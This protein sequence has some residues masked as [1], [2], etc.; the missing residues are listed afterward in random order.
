MPGTPAERRRKAMHQPPLPDADA[1][2]LHQPAGFDVVTIFEALHD[3]GEDPGVG[4][5]LVF[6]YVQGTTLKERLQRGPLT[7]VVCGREG[8][9]PG[10]GEAPSTSSRPGSL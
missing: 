1:A 8:A 9:S 6:E 5:F 4:L 7:V 3:M 10:R 2:A